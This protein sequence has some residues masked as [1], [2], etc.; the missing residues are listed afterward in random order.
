M[1]RA[2]RFLEAIADDA[3]VVATHNGEFHADDAFAVATLV[4]AFKDRAV[5]VLRTRDPQQLGQAD[6][7]VDVGAI[8]DPKRG[9]FDHHQ[10]GGAGEREDGCPLASFGLVWREY[11][12]SICQSREVAECVD[13]RLVYGVD[14][15]DTGF[16]QEAGGHSTSI[17]ISQL[18]PVW[19]DNE[20]DPDVA[21]ARA[22]DLA[23]SVLDRQIQVVQAEIRAVE[24]L[25]E[26]L[27]SAA[28]PRIVS[29]NAPLPWNGELQARSEE[30][31]FVVFPS[32]T[33]EFMVQC[34]PPDR[35]S[36]AQRLPLPEAWAGLR[37]DD[38]VHA[39]GVSD[40]I[41][42]HP[43][44]FIGGAMSRAGALSLAR[45]AIALAPDLRQSPTP[46]S[47]SQA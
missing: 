34:V 47:R 17:M 35:G 46:R 44:R 10:R 21:F 42:C 5:R 11:G 2:E 3:L 12:E 14:A 29:L 15:A 4:R 13:K 18:N 25:E 33:G 16:G 38:L 26:A 43:G 28:D 45:R 41:F 9:S 24:V 39:S 31:L 36:F 40:A 23:G 1:N 27:A 8:Y 32:S 6:F 20:T 7:R 37:G 22:V 19:D 30:A